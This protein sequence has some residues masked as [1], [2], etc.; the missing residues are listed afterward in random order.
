MRKKWPAEAQ[1][2]RCEN[3]IR[4]KKHTHTH[5][6]HMQ[7]LKMSNDARRRI[8]KIWTGQKS[9]L[10][11]KNACMA[12][13]RHRIACIAR[14]FS[15]SFPSCPYVNFIA[16]LCMEPKYACQSHYITSIY[17]VCICISISKQWIGTATTSERRLTRSR[18][19]SICRVRIPQVE[20]S[21]N[22]C[23][24]IVSTMPK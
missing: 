14:I 10:G 12:V 8:R 7:P 18:V 11:M 9:T 17:I 6:A 22:I 15:H 5:S 23:H 24:R 13:P 16:A 4:Y 19:R 20:K 1:N 21:I 3:T 2:G